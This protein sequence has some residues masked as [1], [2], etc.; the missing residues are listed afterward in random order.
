MSCLKASLKVP[1]PTLPGGLT[2][3]FTPPSIALDPDL[4]CKITNFDIP[5]G[6]VTIPFVMPPEVAAA[7]EELE[8]TV[9]DF[10]RAAE[11]NLD[12]PGD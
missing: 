7:L 2:V 11:L 6:G 4:C 3:G 8:Q 1:L 10:N 9:D 12:C 5:L